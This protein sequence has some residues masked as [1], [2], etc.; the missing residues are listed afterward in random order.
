MSRMIEFWELL[1]IREWSRLKIEADTLGHAIRT[2]REPNDPSLARLTAFHAAI[3]GHWASVTAHRVITHGHRI[4]WLCWF[5]VIL[6]ALILWRV[7]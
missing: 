4:A 7:W 6:L 1:G 3:T 2:Y 5:Q